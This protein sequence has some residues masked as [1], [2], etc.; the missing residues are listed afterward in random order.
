[1]KGRFSFLVILFAVEAI[2][3]PT[4]PALMPPFKPT[5]TLRLSGGSPPLTKTTAFNFALALHLIE[6]RESWDS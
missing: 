6:V 5:K 2:A 3:L 4:K 1:M